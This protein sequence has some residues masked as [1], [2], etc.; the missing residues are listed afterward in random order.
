MYYFSYALTY[1]E[2][3]SMLELGPSKE[4]DNDN[5]DIPPYLI[6]SW[7]TQRKS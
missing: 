5:M 3:Q 2:I 6:D 4:F 1:S 7:W